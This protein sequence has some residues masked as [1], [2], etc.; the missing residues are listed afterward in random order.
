LLKKREN[1]GVV[2]PVGV[3]SGLY[4]GGHFAIEEHIGNTASIYIQLTTDGELFAPANRDRYEQ[5]C[6]QDETI[7]TGSMTWGNS[8]WRS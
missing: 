2:A 7:Y 1:L 4:A 6:W 8:Y 3:I 5:S